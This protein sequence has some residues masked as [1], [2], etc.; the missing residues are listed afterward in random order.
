MVADGKNKQQ[1]SQE[2]AEAGD[3]GRELRWSRLRRPV[4]GRGEGMGMLIYEAPPLSFP[5]KGRSGRC[6]PGGQVTSHG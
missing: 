2:E 3:T 6:R 4:K 5:L 1:L